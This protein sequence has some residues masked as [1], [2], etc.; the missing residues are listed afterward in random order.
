MALRSLDRHGLD[1]LQIETGR[2]TRVFD[3]SGAASWSP[4]GE[5]LAIISSD[6]AAKS[7]AALYIANADGT[8]YRKIANVSA[9]G[10]VWS[11]RGDQIAILR[12][13]VQE[14]GGYE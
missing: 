10:P 3:R 9:G 1:V 12:Q 7:S 13:Y 4:N 6:S 5:Q 8:G 14:K 11:P 2:R